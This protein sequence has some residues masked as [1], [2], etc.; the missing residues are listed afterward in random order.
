MGAIQRGHDQHRVLQELVQGLMN[1]PVES[2]LERFKRFV[3][4]MSAADCR[5]AADLHVQKLRFAGKHLPQIWQSWL[6]ASTTKDMTLEEA[7][8]QCA[9]AAPVSVHP[10]RFHHSAAAANDPRRSSRLHV[11]HTDDATTPVRAPRRPMARRVAV[12][13]SIP[14]DGRGRVR[15]LNT[16]HRECMIRSELQS[17]IAYESL[18]DAERALRRVRRSYE[19]GGNGFDV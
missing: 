4:P 15:S 19:N 13:H 9:A 3:D 2:I 6:G 16:V 5:R 7:L 11:M 10:S 14:T 8:I 17:S 12:G 1:A 18:T